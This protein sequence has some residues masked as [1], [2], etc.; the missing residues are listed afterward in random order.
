MNR[1]QFLILV[2]ALIVLGGAGI[3]LFYQD[4]AAYRASGAKIG[5]RLLPELK[6]A[7]VAQIKLQ[8]GKSQV[9]LVRKETGWVVRERGDYP[10]GFQQ[11]SDL[12]VKLYELKVTQAET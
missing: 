10:A 2:I 4:I 11:I 1:K 5:A 8:D 12:L 9:T 7:E 6:L 3:A